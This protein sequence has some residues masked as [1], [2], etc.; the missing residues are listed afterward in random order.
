MTTPL[1]AQ[2]R[3]KSIIIVEDDPTAAGL[4]RE[5]L[6]LEGEAAWLVRVLYDGDA[7][8]AAITAA[9]PD[10]VLLDLRLPGRDGGAIFR[11]LRQR[12][13][14]ARLPVLFISGATT[15]ELHQYGVDEG[16]LLRKP[17]DLTTLVHVVR[18]H[19]RAA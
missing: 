16:V 19:L 8:I 6:E 18:A 7:A 3:M 14:T 15:A 12:P 17:V 11:W 10:L 13:S 2:S 5:A 4:L 9:P 1:L